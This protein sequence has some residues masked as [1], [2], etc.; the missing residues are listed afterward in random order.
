VHRSDDPVAARHAE[1]WE[2]VFKR[3]G[4]DVD[5]VRANAPTAVA[6]AEQEHNTTASPTTSAGP[7]ELAGELAAAE[8]AAGAVAAGAVDVAAAEVAKHA[9]GAAAAGTSQWSAYADG[10]PAAA[11]GGRGVSTPP[12]HVLAQAREKADLA[13]VSAPQG[14]SRAVELVHTSGLDR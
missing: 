8:V 13:A 1:Q 3:E 14:A 12:N 7:A 11:L 2:T 10:A 9:Q 6:A 5:D 4:I